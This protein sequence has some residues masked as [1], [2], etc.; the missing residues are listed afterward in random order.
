MSLE[1]DVVRAIGRALD[2]RGAW[3]FKVH[4]SAYQA[5]GIPDLIGCDRGRLFGIEVKEPGAKSTAAERGAIAKLAA[6]GIPTG[7]AGGCSALQA[8]TIRRI[9]AAGGAAG[10]ATSVDEALAILGR[11]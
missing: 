6:L 2:A 5:A 9:I 11:S 8:L 10:V 7:S 1:R 4:G 3:W